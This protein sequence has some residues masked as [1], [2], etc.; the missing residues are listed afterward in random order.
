M[1]K[2]Y[3]RSTLLFNF[4]Q[5]GERAFVIDT[6]NFLLWIEDGVHTVGQS[7]FSTVDTL[8]GTFTLGVLRCSISRRMGVMYDEKHLVIESSNLLWIEDGVHAFIALYGTMTPPSVGVLWCL[9]FDRSNGEGNVEG[10]FVTDT[11]IFLRGG[12]H[13][14]PAGVTEPFIALFLFL[15]FS[16]HYHL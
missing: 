8:C 11:S 5:N 10:H 14:A 13:E 6:S 15:I 4:L 16:G 7:T 9:T 2:I 1:W 3:I 12:V